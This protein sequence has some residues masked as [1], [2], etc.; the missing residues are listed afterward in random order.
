MNRLIDTMDGDET[1][2][3]LSP[4]DAFALLGN[5]IRVQILQTLGDAEEPLSFSTLYDRLPIDDSARFNYHLGELRG[6]FVRKTDAGY[7]L[8]HPGRRVVEAILSGTVTDDPE[9]DRTSVDDRCPTCERRLSIQ[10]RDGSVELFCSGCE[11]RWTKSGGRVGEAAVTEPGYLGR[12]PLPPAGLANRTADEVLRVAYA[13]T[14]LEL[15]AVGSGIC[16]RCAATVETELSVCPDHD[17]DGDCSNCNSRFAALLIGS[18][19]NCI[20]EVGCGAAMALLSSPTLLTFM[21]EHGLD[22][23]SPR[24]V[25]RLDRFLNEYDEAVRSVDPPRVELTFSADGDDLVLR[26]DENGDL[27][28]EPT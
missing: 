12:L 7:A 15:L 6:H 17:E 28:T 23:F 19:T 4:D 25:H 2:D 5:E 13:W 3:R 11:S 9:L 18:C 26:V 16:P 14:N 8:D 24:S 1:S 27:L 10:W 22:P 20:Y 21:F